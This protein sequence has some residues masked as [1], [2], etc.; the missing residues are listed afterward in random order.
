[1]TN[2]LIYSISF[3]QAVAQFEKKN[4]LQ[5]IYKPAFF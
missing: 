5:I 1:M 3:K 4:I 2:F